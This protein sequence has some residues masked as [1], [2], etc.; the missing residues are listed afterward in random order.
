LASTALTAPE[1]FTLSLQ[2]PEE[3]LSAR[4]ALLCCLELQEKTKIPCKVMNHF[5]PCVV[6]HQSSNLIFLF[7][8]KQIPYYY[9]FFP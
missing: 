2:L 9:K 5:A 3:M 6:H 7:T 8:F 4:Q 1:E